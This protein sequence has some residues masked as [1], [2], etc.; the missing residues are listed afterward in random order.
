MTKELF[1]GAMSGDRYLTRNG[2]TLAYDSYNIILDQYVLWHEDGYSLLYQ[3]D[4][5]K[6][7]KL[8]GEDGEDIVA[9][10]LSKASEPVR[11]L[12]LVLKKKW[13]D[14]IDS[15]EKRE[16]YRD[17]TD[18]WQKRFYDKDNVKWRYYDTV[19]FYL[20]YAKDRPQMTFAVDKLWAGKGKPEWGADP[21]RDYFIV[22]L[23]ARIK[24][25][26]P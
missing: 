15:G 10:C 22:Y 8:E 21:N 17:F 19:T 13:Y 18:Y 25:E 16:E 23:G 7:D 4:G 14:M 9:H 5:Q 11:D 12:K 24:K 1:K 20:G 2:T 26:E 3:R 6:V